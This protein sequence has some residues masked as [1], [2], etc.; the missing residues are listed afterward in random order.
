[1]IISLRY[2]RSSLRSA[3]RLA[4]AQTRRVWHSFGRLT[5]RR[6]HLVCL[7][8]LARPVHLGLFATNCVRNKKGSRGARRCNADDEGFSATASTERSG[9]SLCRR[10]PANALSGIWTTN[11]TLGNREKRNAIVEKEKQYVIYCLRGK[12][13]SLKAGFRGSPGS[14]HRQKSS[15]ALAPREC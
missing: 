13:M 1:M 9:G 3:L 11:E 15:C 4:F 14:W 12:A 2:R 8:I 7:T 6:S 10:R 5:L